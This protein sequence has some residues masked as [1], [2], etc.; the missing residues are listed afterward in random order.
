MSADMADPDAT[1]ATT[2]VADVAARLGVSPAHVHL[3]VRRGD[4]ELAEAEN[5]LFQ[6]TDASLRAHLDATNRR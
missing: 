5:G 1:E 3:L 2:P 4:L 6:V